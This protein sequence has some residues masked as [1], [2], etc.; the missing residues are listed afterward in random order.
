MTANWLA[1]I[2]AVYDGGHQLS[3]SA[4]GGEFSLLLLATADAAG[5]IEAVAA[6]TCAGRPAK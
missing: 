3:D 6:G 5:S 4:G 2:P 1:V